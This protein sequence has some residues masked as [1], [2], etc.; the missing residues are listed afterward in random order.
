MSWNK[1]SNDSKSNNSNNYCVT[2]GEDKCMYKWNHNGSYH[3]DSQF[4]KQQICTLESHCSC[5]SFCPFDSFIALGFADGSLKFLNMSKTNKINSQSSTK[6]KNQSL[7]LKKVSTN[8][9]QNKS[10]SQVMFEKVIDNAHHGA[11]TCLQWNS[12]GTDLLTSG[13]D[14][15]IKQWSS[16]GHLRSRLIRCSHVVHAVVWMQKNESIAYADGS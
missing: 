8:D 11:V 7:S 5:L 3:A 13:E 12:D 16:G 14:G 6:T 4:I 15:M 1:F 9:R 10:Q 2:V